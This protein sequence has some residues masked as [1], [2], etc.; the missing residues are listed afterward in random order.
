MKKLIPTIILSLSMFSIYSQS[1]PPLGAKWTYLSELYYRGETGI[2]QKKDTN[3]TVVAVKDTLY[4]GL[5]FRKFETSAYVCL[6]GLE[7]EYYLNEDKGRV[8]YKKKLSDSLILAYD[9]NKKKGD[10]WIAE[11][12]W[13]YYKKVQVD[14]VSEFVV[15][16]Y[17]L[18]RL[19]LTY[20]HCER[21]WGNQNTTV[22]VESYCS[23]VNER[24]LDE[25]YFLNYQ[26]FGVAECEDI[27]VVIKSLKEYKDQYFTIKPAMLSKNCMKQPLGIG[28]LN[29]V[30][31]SITFYPTVAND[32]LQIESSVDL[33]EAEY[34]LISSNGQRQVVS[35]D[36][37]NRL[38]TSIL[39]AGIYLLQV[40]VA[41]S[42]K[43]LKFMKE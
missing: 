28:E 43:T 3:V 15:D 27:I 30:D 37:Y 23:V 40:Q 9:F 18:K 20:Y 16:N 36:S 12:N 21:F 6:H 4:E 31:A 7:R 33:I 35:L 41:D 17:T 5:M 42:I 29:Q 10:T 2:I 38:N 32:F 8:F 39:K 19:H 1:M 24:T 22:M 34:N 11:S 13:A 25:Y 14:S 26:D